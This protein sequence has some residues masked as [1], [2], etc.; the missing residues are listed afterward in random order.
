MIYIAHRGNKKGNI[1]G[2]ENTPN[3]INMAIKD[4]FHVEIDVWYIGGK[5]Y[6]GHDDPKIEVKKNYLMNRKFWIHAKNIQ[7]LEALHKKTNCFFHDKDDAVLTSKN[8]LWIYP[9]KN[10]VPKAV[11]VLPETVKYDLEDLKNCCAICSDNPIYWRD[12]LSKK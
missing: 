12:L 7:A 11:A 2:L 8:F 10:L 3:Y 5:F 6:L 9:G 4:G 1:E